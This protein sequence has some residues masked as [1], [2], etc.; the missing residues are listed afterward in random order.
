MWCG[1]GGALKVGRRVLLL[2]WWLLGEVLL[3]EMLP[4]ELLLREL[5]LLVLLLELLNLHLLPLQP[6]RCCRV[7]LDRLRQFPAHPSSA[8]SLPTST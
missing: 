5:T 2:L 1:V 7:L 3:G 8:H 4:S 6:V